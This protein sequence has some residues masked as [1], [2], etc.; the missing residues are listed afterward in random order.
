MRISE[1]LRELHALQ[2]QFGD[3]RVCIDDQDEGCLLVMQG[4]ESCMRTVRG[5][6]L[7]VLSSSYDHR[8]NDEL[9][10]KCGRTWMV[11]H[12][13]QAASACSMKAI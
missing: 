13:G 3:V 4:G 5:E 2:G 8:L 9:C 1:L 6:K 7:V 10:T 12:E 11:H